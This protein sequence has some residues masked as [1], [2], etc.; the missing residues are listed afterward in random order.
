MARYPTKRAVSAGGVLIDDRPRRRCVL[1]ISR[2]NRA[3][4]LQWTLPK[5]TLEDGE[6][7]P[8]TA[9]REVREETGLTAEIVQKV[10]IID[11]WFVVPEERARYHKYVHY[12]LMRP[13]GGDPADRDDEAED[14]EWL[15]VEE[16]RAR[17]THPNELRLLDEAL[18]AADPP[19]AQAGRAR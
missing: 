19:D 5:G 17:M 12:F 9:I 4:A 8:V 14:V 6:S 13:T 16:A 11:Y 2:R 15:P 3:G 1:L 10:G 18:E 7:P